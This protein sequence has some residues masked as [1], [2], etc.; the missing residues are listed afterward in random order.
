[1]RSDTDTEKEKEEEGKKRN[2]TA[3]TE[4]STQSY[5]LFGRESVSE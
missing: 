1:M 2:D 5:D 3:Y 4:H